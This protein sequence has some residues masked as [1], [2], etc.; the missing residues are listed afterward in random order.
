ATAW[1]DVAAMPPDWVA[2]TLAARGSWR[3]PQ[4]MGVIEAPT[5]KPDGGLLD[6]PGYDAGSGIVFLPSGEFPPIPSSP[7]WEDASAAAARLLEPFADFPFL[8]SEARA[9]AVAAVLSLV[10]RHAIDGCVPLFAVRSP[11]PGT[12]KGLLADVACL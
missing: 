7:T 5:M 8:D 10:A 6:K 4:L 9:A 12:G 2:R 1:K 11:A 3:F